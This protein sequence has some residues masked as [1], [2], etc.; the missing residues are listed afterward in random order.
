MLFAFAIIGVFFLLFG[1][2]W[3]GWRLSHKSACISPYS[4]LP[5]RRCSDLSYYN[6]ERILRFLYEL[7]DYEN[8]I[9]E[10]RR[11]SFCR[12]TGRIFQNSITWFDTISVDWNFI[13]KRY[14]GN[15]VSWGSLS[16]DQKLAIRDRHYDLK[17]F[18]TDYSS[19]TASPRA[20]EPEYAFH[21][22][23]PL[24]VDIDTYVLV[25]WKQVPGTSL[26]LLIVQR[27]KPP[28]RYDYI[29]KV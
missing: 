14:S 8:R 2:F 16:E 19:P 9:F 25:G 3:A 24:Y 11:A 13:N 27:P 12:E 4:G 21:K 29:D 17:G 5:L 15:Y 22:P 1:V 23:G 18:E 6:I 28:V 20:I 26:E 7:Q 10:L